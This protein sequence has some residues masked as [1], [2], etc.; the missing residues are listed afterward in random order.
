MKEGMAI[1]EKQLSEP[2]LVTYEWAKT[3]PGACDNKKWDCLVIELVTGDDYRKS[4]IHIYFES[5]VQIEIHEQL[6]FR[7]ISGKKTKIVGG[8]SRV[9]LMNDPTRDQVQQLL[10]ALQPR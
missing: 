7:P 1:A 6:Y 4:W 2:V 10:A 5:C 3:L 8:Y 9:R